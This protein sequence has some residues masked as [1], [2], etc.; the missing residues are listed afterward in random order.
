M[1]LAIGSVSRLRTRALYSVLNTRRSW[2]DKLYLSKEA[3]EELQ[4]WLESVE[5]F[6]RNP[7]WF[8][9]GTAR[10][11]H[12]DASGS[13]YGGYVVELSND[14]AQGHWT[15]EEVALSSTW[16]ELK[17]VYLV[18]LSFAQ[19]LAGHTVKWFTDNQGVVSI[20]TSGSRR[21]HLQD[22]AMAIFEV[23]LQ[24]SIKLETEWI[25][26]SSNKRADHISRIVDYDDWSVDPHVLQAL[27]ARWGP[28]TIDCFTSGYNALLPQ[29][30]SRFWSPGAEAVDTFTTNWGGEVNWWVPSLHLVSW[31]IRHAAHCKAKGTLLINIPRWKSAP[32]WPILCPDGRHLAAFVQQWW[33][34]NY[35]PSLFWEGRSGNNLGNSMNSDSVVLALF[36]QYHSDSVNVVFVLCMVVKCV[37]RLCLYIIGYV[38]QRSHNSV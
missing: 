26:R 19:R 38:N 18:L 7:I 13:G 32:F 17:A 11:V 5:L 8:S 29:F 20:I 22:G 30:H 37:T 35:Y 27:D 10:L 15:R 34:I 21:Q 23:C 16:R 33:P 4:F 3:W 36:I 1:A 24:Y 25:P 9:S 12:S 28:H 31:T 14:V 2:A 6:N